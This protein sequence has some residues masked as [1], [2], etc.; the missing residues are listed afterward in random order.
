MLLFVS[1]IIT[2]LL[3]VCEIGLENFDNSTISVIMRIVL[4]NV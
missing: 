1:S 2:D 3:K 4:L